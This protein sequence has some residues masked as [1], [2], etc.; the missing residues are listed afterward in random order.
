MTSSSMDQALALLVGWADWA[1]QYWFNEG[2]GRGVWGTGYE[3]WGVQSHQRYLA[4]MAVLGT[5]KSVERACRERCLARALAALRWTLDNHVSGTGRC[6]D[7]TQWGHTWISALGIE[8]MMFGVRRLTP[9]MTDADRDALRRVLT[10]EADWLLHSPRRGDAIGIGASRWDREGRNHPESNLWNGALLWRA[11]QQWPDDP[12]ASAWK[13]Q[14]HRFLINAISV[15]ADAHDERIVAGRP[16]REWHVGPNF[17]DHY[18]LDHH[19][20]MNAG[21]MAICVSN[22][23]ILHFDLAETAQ[24]RPESLDHH[25]AELWSVLRRMVFDDGRLVRLGGDSRVRYAYC[26][27]YLL[28]ALLYAADRLG[29][30]HA[31]AIADAQVRLMAREAAAPPA[32]GGFFSERLRLLKRRL[33]HYHLRLES[34]RACAL[35]MYLAWRSRIS[36]PASRAPDETTAGG[37]WSEPEHGDVLHRGPRRFASFSWR[38][39][40]WT[41]GLC[42]PPDASDLAEYWQNLVSIIRF[43]GDDAADGA[44]PNVPRHRRVLRHWLREVDGGFLTC[45]A[46]MEGVNLQAEGWKA[47]DLAQH[48]IAIAALPD[49]RTF[50]GVERIRIGPRRAWVI[51]LKGVHLG[52]PNDVFNGYRRLLRCPAGMLELTAPAPRDE[53]IPLGGD[54]SNVDGRLGLVVLYGADGLVLSRSTQPRGGTYRSLRVEELCGP[55]RHE[56]F[57]VEPGE[58]ILDLAWAVLASADAAETAAFAERAARRHAIARDGHRRVL[59]IEGLD[60]HRYT[61]HVDFDEP[62]SGIEPMRLERH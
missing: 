31:P 18:A 17:F 51:E 3:H 62:R 48:D 60:G 21:Y 24:P 33:P 10:S 50:V 14:A 49:G 6:V 36:A 26:Q 44:G 46:V 42:L 27:E 40:G 30:A 2:N 57:T 11:A 19:G 29:D 58:M 41:Q 55:F 15:T 25:Q 12:R 23:A 59:G 53:L 9:E 28:P 45:G 61:L 56:P 20:Y 7:G 39:Y 16:V 5:T 22:A 38:A 35:G 37:G 43:A 1:E 13:E 54:W 52:L 47:S 32:D 4:A 8:R 34:D